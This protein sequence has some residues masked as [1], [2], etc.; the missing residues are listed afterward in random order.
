MQPQKLY[1]N[2]NVTYNSNMFSAS[3]RN[4]HPNLAEKVGQPQKKNYDPLT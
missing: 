3:N 1:T 2:Q 4:N